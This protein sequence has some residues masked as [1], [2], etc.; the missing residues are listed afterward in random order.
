MRAKGEC[1]SADNNGLS[2]VLHFPELAVPSVEMTCKV[3]QRRWPIRI[4]LRAKAK[5]CSLEDNGLGEVLHHPE[6]FVTITEMN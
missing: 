1:F 4:L 2:E 5:C 6:L 3:V